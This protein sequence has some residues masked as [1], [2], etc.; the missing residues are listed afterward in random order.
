MTT[1]PEI[2]VEV[3]NTK[4]GLTTCQCRT[5]FAYRVTAADIPEADPETFVE[6]DVY[7]SCGTATHRTYAPG[8]D[9]KLKSLLIKLNREGQQ[10]HYI[11]G[12]ALVDVSPATLA[13]EL[14]WSHFLT[15]AK[16]KAT[17]KAKKDRTGQQGTIKLGRWTYPATILTDNGDTLDVIYTKKNGGDEATT[18]KSEQFS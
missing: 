12:G 9:A 8:H 4:R 18:V 13:A 15:P 1:Q 16:P 17:R 2:T 3:S 5:S 10:Y 11:S 14:S 7:E 6:F